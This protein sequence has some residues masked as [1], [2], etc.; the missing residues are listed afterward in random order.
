MWLANCGPVAHNCQVEP[1]EDM[2]ELISSATNPLAKQVRQL[3]ERKYRKRQGAF[4]VEGIQPTWRAVE[5]GWT[6][7]TF[8]VAPELLAGTPAA[9]MVAE[10]EHAG[11]RVARLTTE[12]FERLCDRDGPAGLAAIV[13]T[14]QRDL[15]DLDVTP[16]AM[17]TVLH[18]ISNPGNLGT[19][20]RTVDAV[21]GDGIILVGNTTDP[22]SPTAV[23]ASMGSL[24]TV[25]VVY[26]PDLETF[27]SWAQDHDVTTVA[28]SGRANVD[29]WDAEFPTPI[30][31][32]MGSERK[33]L[34]ESA[35]TG[36]AQEIR[37]PMGGTAES[38]NVG[39]AASILL[40]E[41]RRQSR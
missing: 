18:E 12:L 27:F 7:D 20:I 4:L 39:V 2:I 30:A 15:T 33:G 6:I 38:L 19:I 17:F 35:L 9:V 23:K 29:H 13:R 10:Q 8:I 32:L 24:F 36:A 31:L 26:S 22:W 3:A 34:P 16:G 37:I 40:Y 28:T 11:T 1:G 41:V 25:P 14:P 21:E 5:A